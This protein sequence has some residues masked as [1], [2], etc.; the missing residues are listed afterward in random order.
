MLH[1]KAE[2]K[3]HSA[4]QI[5]GSRGPPKAGVTLLIHIAKDSL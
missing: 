1:G 3:I 5:D 4:A 2:A